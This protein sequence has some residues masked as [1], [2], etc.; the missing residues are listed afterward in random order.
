MLWHEVNDTIEIKREYLACTWQYNVRKLSAL[1]A[2]P[3]T[4]MLKSAA[5]KLDMFLRMAN[6]EEISFPTRSVQYNS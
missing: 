2:N 6:R 1:A 5:R 4:F 3:G